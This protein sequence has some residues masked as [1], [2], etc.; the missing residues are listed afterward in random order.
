MTI[1]SSW[2]TSFAGDFD[3]H[4][5]APVRYWLHQPMRRG[6]CFNLSHWT[7]QLVEYLLCIALETASIQAIDSKWMHLNCWRFWWPWQCASTV[8]SATT[9]ALCSALQFKPLDTTIGQILAPYRPGDRHSPIQTSKTNVSHL[10]EI[11]MVMAMRQYGTKRINTR[12]VLSAS[13]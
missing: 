8:S 7:P 4:G 2:C 1:T 6:H 9:H 11:L 13:T 5:N 3:V 10:L 12:V